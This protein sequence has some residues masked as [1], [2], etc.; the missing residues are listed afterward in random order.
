[1]L[2]QDVN[3]HPV[4]IVML[5]GYINYFKWFRRQLQYLTA[6]E[7][8]IFKFVSKVF[9]NAHICPVDQRHT[10]VLIPLQF[11]F[12]IDASCLI[13]TK[14]G[15]RCKFLQDDYFHFRY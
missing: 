7:P 4:L 15:L 6:F 2:V 5:T 9:P 11:P 12:E 3:N 14:H 8:H 13:H 10:Q 1:M